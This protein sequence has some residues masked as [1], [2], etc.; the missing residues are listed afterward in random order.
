MIKKHKDI[1][2]L[3]VCL[4]AIFQLYLYTT[5]PAFKNDDSP[6]TITSAYTLGISHPPGYPL[7]TIMGKVFSVLPVGSPAFRINLFAIFLGL[8]VL[9]LFYFIIKQNIY[10]IFK[11]NSKIINYFGIFVLAFTFLFWNQTIEA[12]GGIYILN[13]LFLSALTYLSLNLF[14]KFNTGRFYLLIYI[15]GLSLTNHWPSMLVFFPALGYIFYKYREKSSRILNAIIIG[16]KRI[17]F[18]A[19]KNTK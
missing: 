5:F 13:L 2:L 4:I 7:F 8:M 10:L 19:F 1:I 16:I 3:L 17:R 14:Y 18:F 9:L 11:D 12:K 15:F 6:E